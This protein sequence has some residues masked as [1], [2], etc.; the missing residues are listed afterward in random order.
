MKK[1]T[2]LF[3]LLSIFTGAKAQLTQ[4]LNNKIDY[5]SKQL[6]IE[7]LYLSF[8]KPFYSVGDTL[9]F[10]SVLLN[11]DYSASS[12][13]DK[14]Y[15]ELYNDS[16]SLIDNRT[17][18]LNNGLGYGDIALSKRLT[19][20]TYTIRAYSNWQQN[21]GDDYFFQKSFYIGNAGEKTWLLNSLQEISSTVNNRTL[22]LKLRITNL[23]NQ[24]IGLKDIE[25]QLMNGSRRIAKADL[26][27]KLDGTL[28]T[29]IPLGDNKI[30][31]NFNI[32][33]I[34]KKNKAQKSILP[35]KILKQETL[36]LQFMPEGGYMVNGIFGKNCKP[37]SRSCCRI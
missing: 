7:K 26:Q 17:I 28:D 2:L 19:E 31:P 8:D 10:K 32:I 11:A 16:L 4:S 35:V 20:G 9:W 29:K 18:A 24:A 6:P 1:L 23:K 22:D 27:T 30:N 37:K 25:V 5:A 13:T 12:R 14:I 3:I 36:D 21:F 15:V 34:D 33:I